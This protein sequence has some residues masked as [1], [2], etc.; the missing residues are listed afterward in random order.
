MTTILAG[1]V[2]ALSWSMEASGGW[3]CDFRTNEETFVVFADR[4]LRY[5]RGE[6]KAGLDEIESE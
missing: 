4:I 5:Q 6:A 3:Y 1:I 2:H